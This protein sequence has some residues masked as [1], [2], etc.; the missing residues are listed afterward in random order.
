MDGDFH[1]LHNYKKQKS[2]H[3]ALETETGDQDVRN[4]E[5]RP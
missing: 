4:F 5:D 1:S 2:S 3:T